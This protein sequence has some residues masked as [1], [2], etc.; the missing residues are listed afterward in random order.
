MPE[1]K[2]VDT[3]EICRLIQSRN[4]ENAQRDPKTGFLKGP[5]HAQSELQDYMYFHAEDIATELDT[6]KAENE[7]LRGEVSFQKQENTTIEQAYHGIREQLAASQ[8]Q[9]E[10]LRE[11]LAEI[12][13]YYKKDEDFDPCTD[14]MC[15]MPQCIAE[16]ALASTPTGRMARLER[17]VKIASDLI[18]FCNVNSTYHAPNTFKA[19]EQALAALK[20]EHGHGK[21]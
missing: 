4:E 13:H 15:D 16:K 20:E 11:A 14:P 21:D 3:D 5:P 17:I 8:E 6:L 12:V 9:V 19:L 7:R 18:Q 1:V 2:P 10:R